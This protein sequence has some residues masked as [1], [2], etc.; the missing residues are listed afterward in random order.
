MCPCVR[1]ASAPQTEDAPAN[2]PADTSC[3]SAQTTKLV[4]DLHADH[5]SMEL[6]DPPLARPLGF[7]TSG[8]TSGRT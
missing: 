8:R 3:Q 5:R 2:Q 7:S 6:V 1:T 4:P